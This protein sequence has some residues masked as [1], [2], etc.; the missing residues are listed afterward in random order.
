MSYELAIKNRQVLEQA[1]KNCQVLAQAASKFGADYFKHIELKA[2]GADAR[3]V[4]YLALESLLNMEISIK[5]S[6]HI[7]NGFECPAPLTELPSDGEKVYFC[8]LMVPEGYQWID[9]RLAE[10]DYVNRLLELGALFH[11]PEDAIDNLKA[12]YPKWVPG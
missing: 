12:I 11:T 2:K 9:L 7:L 1:I 8:S 10:K 6:T 4:G 3:R 5:K